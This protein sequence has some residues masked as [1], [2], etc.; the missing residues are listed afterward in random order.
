MIFEELL[1]NK[2]NVYHLEGA[3]SDEIA[4]LEE[5]LGLKFADDYKTYLGTYGLLSY[6]GHE[7]T[8]FCKS[9]RLNVLDSTKREKAENE[10]VMSNMYLLE[11][12]GVENM[13]IWQDSDGLVYEVKY[14]KA[15]EKICDSLFEYIEKF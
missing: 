1:L 6:D 11:Y 4:K 15:P 14:K 5:E 10:A 13:T 2:N 3:R 9:P 8:G 7:L 12:V